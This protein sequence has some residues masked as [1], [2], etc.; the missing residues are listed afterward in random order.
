MD[1]VAGGVEGSLQ[2]GKILDPILEQRDAIPPLE[3]H[4]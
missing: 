4:Q 2:R 1:F 3:I